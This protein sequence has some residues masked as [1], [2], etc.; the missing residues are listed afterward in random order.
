M[1]LAGEHCGLP[2]EPSL[3]THF[4]QDLLEAQIYPLALQ[5]DDPRTVFQKE[6]LE[7]APNHLREL[8]PGAEEMESCLRVVKVEEL[9]PGQG[10]FLVM[11]EEIGKAIAWFQKRK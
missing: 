11:N 3:G 5:L 10:L 8:L 6:L 7:D 1:E 4:F 9:A 2:P